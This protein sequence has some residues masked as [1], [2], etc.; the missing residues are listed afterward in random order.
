MAAVE[1][2]LLRVSALAD[3][4]PELLECDLNPVR[5]MA[6]GEG[7][8]ALDARIRVASVN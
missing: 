8:V 7:C 5:A 2:L 1:D 6:A 3:A 4:C